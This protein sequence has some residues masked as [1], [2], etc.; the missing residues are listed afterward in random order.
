VS[1]IIVVVKTDRTGP[2]ASMSVLY[3][4]RSGFKLWPGDQLL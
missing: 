1:I 2:V 3:S 4:G